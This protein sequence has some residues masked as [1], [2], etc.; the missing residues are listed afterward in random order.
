MPPA[1][2]LKASTST[3]ETMAATSAAG[4]RH[5]GRARPA[6]GAGGRLRPGSGSGPPAVGNGAARLGGVRRSAP[7]GR[8]AGAGADHAASPAPG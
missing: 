2:V 5:T 7:S 6:T 8:V 1:E 3:A 4:D